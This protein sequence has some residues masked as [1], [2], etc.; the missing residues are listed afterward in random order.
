MWNLLPGILLASALSTAGGYLAT[1]VSTTLMGLPREKPPVISPIMMS[2][3]LGMCVRNTLGLPTICTTGI[4]CCL[5]KILRL[6]IVLL[7]IRLS[8]TEA[9]EIGGRALPVI[10][11]S[12]ASALFLVTWL[13]VRLG[14]SSKLGA[15]I[16]A[17]TG[18]CGAT[19]IVALAPSILATDE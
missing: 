2:I 18:I 1:V 13:S 4:Q 11:A 19:A 10:M 8:L 3:V 6:G 12:V 16:A 17:G 7:G 5:T 9:S 14:L 15:L